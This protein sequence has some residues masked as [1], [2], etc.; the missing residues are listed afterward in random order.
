VALR[1]AEIADWISQKAPMPKSKAKEMV[2]ILLEIIKRAMESGD[3][4]MISR[5]GKFCVKE[6]G[7]R[8]GRNPTTGDLMVLRPR[9]VVTFKC[10]RRLREKVNGTSGETYT[11]NG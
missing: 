11:S 5:F 2:E 8:R 9:R 7:E 6:K 1:K 3:D 4:V 10:S